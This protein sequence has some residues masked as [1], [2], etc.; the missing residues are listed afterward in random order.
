MKFRGPKL[1]LSE[2]N[3]ACI[4]C[5]AG[6]VSQPFGCKDLYRKRYIEDGNSPRGV[7]AHGR[8]DYTLVW[9]KTDRHVSKDGKIRPLKIICGF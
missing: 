3:D 4:N 6:A 1:R 8:S 2:S 5:R 9:L 7:L